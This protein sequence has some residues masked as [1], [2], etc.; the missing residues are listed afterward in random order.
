MNR[1]K[2]G[3]RKCGYCGKKYVPY[4]ETSRFCS[5]NCTLDYGRFVTQGKHSIEQ[6]ICPVCGET[7][8]PESKYRQAYQNFCSHKCKRVSRYV[9][10]TCKI[11]WTKCKACNKFFASKSSIIK[12][13]PQCRESG[14]MQMHYYA[15]SG[16]H[17]R[18]TRAGVCKECGEV[19]VNKYG[20]KR[21]VYCSDECHKKAYKKTESYKAQTKRRNR[22]RRARMAGANS[23]PYND[24]DIFNRDAWICQICGTLVD[25]N[26]RHPHPL[27]PTIDH[28]IPL[29]KG[30]PDEPGNV[31]LAHFICNS[32][33]RDVMLPAQ[34][35]R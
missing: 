29:S 24:I 19:F 25:K 1:R 20:D 35:A 12:F 27:S 31:Q 15:Q 7:F 17:Q 5:E 10:T 11:H 22:R 14:K 32:R 21:R 26:T 34:G 8:K 4:R 2:Y 16:K 23:I 3:E 9:G 30:G 18:K 6:K 33:K 13:C 28:I